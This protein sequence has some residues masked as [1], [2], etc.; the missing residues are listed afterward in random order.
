MI[1]NLRRRTVVATGSKQRGVALLASL[2]LMLAVV[3][4]LANIF[5]RH[6]IN[7]AQATSA[8]HGDQ[9]LLL[10]ISGENWARDLLSEGLDDPDVDSFDEDWAQAMPLM[11]VDGGQL[12][13]CISD[14]DRKS[15]V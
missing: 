13:G 6:Q 7:V 1:V 12:S 15:V 10:A 4:A 9:A 11:P 3:M 8:L 2:I 5:Y 14:L